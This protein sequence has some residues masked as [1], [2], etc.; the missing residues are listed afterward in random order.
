MASVE[1]L[2]ASGFMLIGGDG[3]H[4]EGRGGTRGGSGVS[5]PPRGGGARSSAASTA[6]GDPTDSVLTAGG[7]GEAHSSQLHVLP[8]EGLG[9]EE[10]QCVVLAAQLARELSR[11]EPAVLMRVLDAAARRRVQGGAALP[12]LGRPVE[13]S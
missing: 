12:Q 3:A 11:A 8:D 13:H 2:R 6:A 7:D 4:L 1:D 10:R 9:D 5:T